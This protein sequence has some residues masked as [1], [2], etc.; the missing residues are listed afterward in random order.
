[1]RSWKPWS[2]A[3]AFAVLGVVWMD[4]TDPL[5]VIFTPNTYVAAYV[6]I[7]KDT[8]F[9]LLTA[10]LIYKLVLRLVASLQASR[11]ELADNVDELRATT[12]A[13]KISDD[14]LKDSMARAGEA[15]WEWWEEDDSVHLGADVRTLFDLPGLALDLGST[16]WWAIIHP[17]DRTRI[18]E[19]RKA[20][21]T[22]HIDRY[23]LLFRAK[24]SGGGWRWLLSTGGLDRRTPRG[25]RRAVGTLRDISEL[26]KRDED[27]IVINATL[28]A[29]IAVNH[30]IIVAKSREELL[31]G[32]CRTLVEELP[33]TAVWIGQ[34]LDDDARTVHPVARAGP[35]SDYV[36]KVKITWDDSPTGRGLAGEAIRTRALQYS[37]DTSTDSRLEPWRAMYA[38][39]GITS[40]IVIPIQCS[41]GVWGVIVAHGVSIDAFG[42][43]EREV[44]S[45]CG[46]D[47]G[48]ALAALDV[49]ESAAKS[50]F[51]RTRA[52]VDLNQA[53]IGTVRALAAAVEARDPYT[54]GHETRVAAL[55][56]KIGQRL[57]LTLLQLDGLIL[58]G[59]LHDIGK[60]GVPAE[61]LSKP[62]RLTKSEMDVVREH[63][64]IGREIVRN[65]RF[66][67]PIAEIIG[68]HHERINGTGYPD[69]LKGEQICIEARILAVADVIEAMLSHRPYRPGLPLREAIEELQSG[70]GTKYWPDAVD[71]C[72]E[73]VRKPGFSVIEVG[74]GFD[75]LP[76]TD[77]A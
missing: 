35:K 22:D 8:G 74:R 56:V 71:A 28:H 77:A 33:L 3:T 19:T 40:S 41:V 21:F 2:I 12:V 58:G 23:E 5:V 29:L 62:G 45:N 64:K 27:L 6:D 54:A 44:F 52:L 49:V 66:P 48:F 36:D 1:M 17:A 68:Q 32:V 67:W 16:D 75:C 15:T 18:E 37:N 70:R 72:L 26:H 24:K 31:H 60:I 20:I 47:I 76:S 69:G 13:L 9:V 10:W 61:F 46:E 65:I 55:A 30:T 38:D 43:R 25:H 63:P 39:Q 14:H 4:V 7:A 53:T 59:S 11:K 73:I 50:E 42:Q 57:G 51:G 34:A